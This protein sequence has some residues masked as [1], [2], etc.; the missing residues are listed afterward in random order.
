MTRRRHRPPQPSDRRQQRAGRHQR[1]LGAERGEGQHVRAGHSAVLDVADDGD[2]QPV[3][4]RRPSAT[5]E[6]PR[7]LGPDRVAVEQG[8][9][10]VLVPAVA[11]VDHR[12]RRSSGRSARARRPSG[13]GRRRRRRPW[14]RCVST[15]SRRL[16]P[17]F[18]LTT[19][20]T[21]KVMVSAESRLAAVSNESRVR[22][23]SSK[24]SDT[25]GPAPQRRHL[26]DRAPADLDHVV[27]ELEHVVD[28]SSASS[29]IESRWRRSLIDAASAARAIASSPA[30]LVRGRDAVAARRRPDLVEPGGQVLADVVGADR[31]LAVAAVDHARPA[32]R[33]AAGRSR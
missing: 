4:R 8:L 16:S 17:L 18:T 23:E 33:P 7:V 30:P 26:R 14:R 29:S 20:P 28:P 6:R 15:V 32:A 22:V 12:G 19:R 1:D 21:E 10:G 27:G 2:V 11:G 24:N 3:E 5:A 25:H 9:G 13:G 31:Q